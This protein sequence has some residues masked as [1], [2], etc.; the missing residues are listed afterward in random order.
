MNPIDV[1]NDINVVI[2]SKKDGV[3]FDE[4]GCTVINIILTNEGK[5]ANT[6]LGVHNEY[7]IKQLEKAQKM[8]LKALKKTLK[9]ERA[10]AKMIIDAED[11]EKKQEEE[12]LKEE[13]KESN[14]A[15]NFQK[16]ND[17]TKKSMKENSKDSNNSNQSD[18]QKV[19]ETESSEMEHICNTKGKRLIKKR[20]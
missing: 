13:S 12:V 20:M 11:Q 17:S 15:S 8:Y 19:V 2:K 3:L 6:F 10:N 5:I 4:N 1:E 14:I 9:E 7:I 18:E 16:S